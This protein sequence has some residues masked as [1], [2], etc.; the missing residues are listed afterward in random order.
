MAPQLR[1]TC[2]PEFPPEKLPN[3]CKAIILQKSFWNAILISCKVYFS[4]IVICILYFS[5]TTIYIFLCFSDIVIY[6]FQC[7]PEFP[8][9]IRCYHAREFIAFNKRVSCNPLFCRKVGYCSILHK[10]SNLHAGKV[11]SSI[12]Y[13]IL[14]DN[15][16]QRNFNKDWK[17]HLC[18]SCWKQWWDDWWL[19]TFVG[20]VG[21]ELQMIME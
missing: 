19:Y 9:S 21:N 14:L 20:V 3:Q 13:N 8:S 15:L 1:P 18:C 5:H 6:V 2:S 12:R 4:D 7:T 16:N 11:S 17:A 10:F